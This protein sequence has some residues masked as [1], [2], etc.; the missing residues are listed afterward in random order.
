MLVAVVLATPVPSSALYGYFLKGCN[1]LPGGGWETISG[2][3]V[4]QTGGLFDVLG[5]LTYY[6]AGTPC[7]TPA[8]KPGS[9]DWPK[10]LHVHR[11][12]ATG[13]PT[14]AFPT[15]PSIKKNECKKYY[16][17]MLLNNG[18]DPCASSFD[19]DDDQDDDCQFGDPNWKRNC[20]S[21]AFAKSGITDF[22][23][24]VIGDVSTGA[25]RVVDGL[26]EPVANPQDDYLMYMSGGFCYHANWVYIATSDCD[27]GSLK[28]KLGPS[29]IFEY[30]YDDPPGRDPAD[31]FWGGA[32]VYY[33][34]DP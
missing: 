2:H 11:N 16:E 12:N 19:K 23:N 5:D 30:D 14:T 6:P 8:H 27:I 34:P 1:Q 7:G 10:H 25:D 29:Q 33:K 26:Y 15:Y 17:A 3:Y 28:F 13:W 18:S 9:E 4:V 22:N 24:I 32:P 20:Y 21:Y 31:L